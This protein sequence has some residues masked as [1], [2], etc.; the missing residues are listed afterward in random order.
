MSSYQ[1]QISDSR[2]A[3]SYSLD[4]SIRKSNE[5][6][7]RFLSSGN[8]G[9]VFQVT[10]TKVT[11]E[12]VR[13][14]PILSTERLG[15]KPVL[16]ERR[17]E[18]SESKPPVVTVPTNIL[19]IEKTVY[20]NRDTPET[21]RLI[22]QTIIENN[23]LKRELEAL[24]MI[25]GSL[26]RE[27]DELRAYKTHIE[28]NPPEAKHTYITRHIE[29]VTE[30][31]KN[32]TIESEREYETRIN[33][34]E[35]TI[36]RLRTEIDS[37]HRQRLNAENE[38]IAAKMDLENAEQKAK[39]AAAKAQ[40]DALAQE[41]L[42]TQV[43]REEFENIKRTLVSELEE[44]RGRKRATQAD[45]NR[46]EH[47][48]TRQVEILQT[49]IIDLEQEL[50]RQRNRADNEARNRVKAETDLRES[51]QR[52]Q[53][54]L[55]D[56]KRI[57]E[58][59]TETTTKR[60]E[61]AEDENHKL[62]QEVNRLRSNDN[63]VEIIKSTERLVETHKTELDK[64]LREREAAEKRARDLETRLLQSETTVKGLRSQID[65][66][67]KSRSQLDLGGVLEERNRLL[68]KVESLESRLRDADNRIAKQSEELRETLKKNTQ[69]TITRRSNYP[70]EFDDTRANS[71]SFDT[72]IDKSK[73]I[74]LE[75]Q[76]EEANSRLRLQKDKKAKLK[77]ELF[78]VT[79]RLVCVM[80]ELERKSNLKTSKNSAFDK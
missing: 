10:E 67:E 32:T 78:L 23:N 52:Q 73:L 56:M 7:S 1:S 58:Q 21:Q 16:V 39:L 31:D 77:R 53:D 57:V 13:E 62:K 30:K 75:H 36:D 71:V 25:N 24:R 48:Q 66:L 54:Q 35:S 15:D 64:H 74:I 20:V 3:T 28:N 37:A 19:P 34:L 29:T 63:S 6:P 65:S 22:A 41:E 9:H 51:T 69:E 38:L 17:V 61:M 76:L 18:Y 5:F 72:G 43:L 80:S 2:P 79:L 27:R 11:S 49:K 26:V 45:N 8:P 47:E 68:A 44:E 42:R 46:N 12:N 60:I 4:P 50:S 40:R 14:L 70:S 33:D 59:R 55:N